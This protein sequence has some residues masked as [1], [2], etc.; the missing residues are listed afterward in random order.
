MLPKVVGICGFYNRKT[1]TQR[2]IRFFLNQDYSGHLTLLLYNN[3]PTQYVLENI[4]FPENR[5][6]ILINNNK[7]LQTGEA[8]VNTGD[9]FRDSLTFVPE[10]DIISF[11]DSD[12]YY[13]PNHVSEGVKGIQKAYSYD[14]LGYKPY[15]SWFKYVG[16]PIKLLH[17]TMEP[18]IFCNA[19]F[20][21]KEGMHSLTASYHLRWID[22]LRKDKLLLEDRDGI[23]TFIYMWNGDDG[24][25]KTSSTGD[26][27][28]AFQKI[29]E[30]EADMGHKI[31]GPCSI[32]EAQKCYD[33]LN[34][35]R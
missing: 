33:I 3:G 4:E 19:K 8:Y 34:E 15:H 18:S 21:L 11:W 20:L 14:M 9:I 13:L 31:L 22:A 1:C 26:S 6:I 32:E 10:C 17:N 30:W 35:P 7:D 27:P 24:V 16:D 12:D 28:E 23:P 25:Y 29:R 2:I 5:Q